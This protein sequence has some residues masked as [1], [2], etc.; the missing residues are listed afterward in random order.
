MRQ[1]KELKVAI[2]AVKAAGRV[3]MSHFK[4]VHYVRLKSP[5]QGIVTEA[6]LQAQKKIKKVIL[7]SFPKAKFFAEEDKV[8]RVR[9]DAWLIDPIDGT[10]NFY[11]GLP[12]FAV[13]VALVK[14]RKPVLGVIYNP[15]T[16]ELFVAEKGK[17]AFL[18][19]ERLHVSKIGDPRQAM[20]DI[21]I[22]ARYGLRQKHFGMFKKLI[23]KIGNVRIL[24][25]ATLRFTEIASG[26]MDAYIEFGI[27]AW[28]WAAGAVIVQEAGGKVTNFGGKTFDIF[29]DRE[30]F[31]SNGKLHRQ[32]IE[33]IK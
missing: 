3:I 17:G 27:H 11:R 9:D 30:I 6:D 2:E 25:A 20:F 29:N 16:K 32:V 5:A 28:D 4:H 23:P 13:S 18:G 1:S 15:V 33:A 31:A 10:T 26:H 7:K 22:S 21:P 24:G 19:G 8:H 14:N 12:L